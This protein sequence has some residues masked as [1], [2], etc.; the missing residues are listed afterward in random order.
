M[1]QLH[2]AALLTAI[3]VTPAQPAPTDP[4]TVA[5]KAPA[6]VADG[7]RWYDVE[8]TAPERHTDCEHHEATDATFARKGRRVRLVLR[9]V[10]KGRWC[11]GEYT[12]AVYLN[13]RVRCDDRID[14]GECYLDRRLGIV[15]FTVAP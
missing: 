14:D 1:S 4:V 13:R 7:S 9:P 6:A 12:G 3:V 5:F 10:D 8:V 15:R 11:P 2:A